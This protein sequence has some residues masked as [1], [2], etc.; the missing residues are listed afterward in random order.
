MKFLKISK[1]GR[2]NAQNGELIP[3]NGSKYEI[4]HFDLAL[5]CIHRKH[6]YKLKYR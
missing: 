6:Q 5:K 2:G 4:P 3:K 1:S